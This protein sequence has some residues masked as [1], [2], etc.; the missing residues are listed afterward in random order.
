MGYQNL[1]PRAEQAMSI[2]NARNSDGARILRHR[3]SD[4]LVGETCVGPHKTHRPAAGWQI[5]AIDITNSPT[6]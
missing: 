1:G 2:H 6:C 3:L 4:G 5:Y